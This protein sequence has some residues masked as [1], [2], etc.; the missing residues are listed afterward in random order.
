M[1][2]VLVARINRRL[3]GLLRVFPRAREIPMEA[4]H[5]RESTGVMT[6]GKEPGTVGTAAGVGGGTIKLAS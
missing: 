6:S 4:S 5:Y 3:A 2:P 1:V